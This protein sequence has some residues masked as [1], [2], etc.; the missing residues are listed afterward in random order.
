MNPLA[1]GLSV[2]LPALAFGGPPAA[3]DP[4]TKVPAFPTSCYS[5]QDNF[6]KD[7]ESALEAVS[8]E[9]ARQEQIN[10]E[11]EERYDN[12]DPAEKQTRMQTYMMAHPQEMAKMMQANQAMG[13]EYQG[14]ATAQLEKGQKLQEELKDLQT[15]YNTAL[16]KA[17]GPLAEKRNAL[18][19]G[20]GEAAAAP[21]AIEE[22][23][24]LIK[25]AN[26]EYERVCQEWW[27]ASGPFQAWLKRDREH[28]QKGASFEEKLEETKTTQYAMM[29]VPAASYRSTEGL[30][31]VQEYMRHAA[32]IF[33]TRWGR[34]L[35]PDSGIPTS[36]TWPASKGDRWGIS[37]SGGLEISRK[38]NYT[39]FAGPKVSGSLAGAGVR[40]RTASLSRDIT[41]AARLPSLAGRSP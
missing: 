2:F 6:A 16:D 34:P 3:Q 8:A 27:S 20:S 26:A 13:A 40:S 21:G 32:Q 38:G 11:I 10:N 36:T 30:G 15:R 25:K 4:W 1:I 5:G 28:L 9:S 22:N 35:T 19:L 17:L 23:K 12:L 29:G 31:A 41:P 18:D 7:T 37:G 33:G 39:I 24:V 14:T